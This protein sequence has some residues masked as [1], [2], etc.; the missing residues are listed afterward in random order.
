[1]NDE[2]YLGRYYEKK[3]F[4]KYKFKKDSF[5]RDYTLVSYVVSTLYFDTNCILQVKAGGSTSKTN[6]VD[7]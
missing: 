7:R 2:W 6:G 5:R 4:L 1:M 3:N